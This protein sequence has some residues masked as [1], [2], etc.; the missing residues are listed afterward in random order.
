MRIKNT[1]LYRRFWYVKKRFKGRMHTYRTY[2]L[3][4]SM[5]I[6]FFILAS[7]AGRVYIPYIDE[8]SEYRIKSVL[9]GAIYDV[10]RKNLSSGGIDF[11]EMATVNRNDDGSIAAITMNSVK[12]GE[13]SARIS[14]E[15]QGAIDSAGKIKIKVPLGAMLGRTMFYNMG[16]CINIVLRQH[17]NI[18]TDFLSEFTEAGMNQV[19]HSI[20]LV[21]KVNF[22]ASV[23]FIRKRY[24]MATTVPLVETIIAGK[25]PQLLFESQ[26]KN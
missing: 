10:I 15:I 16:P 1:L 26:N 13:I 23:A 20:Y 5:I 22:G 21:V 6:I 2:F 3:I 12:I 18:E 25:V 9:N 11:S 24:D 14:R 8:F 17:G 4:T 7:Y 19:K